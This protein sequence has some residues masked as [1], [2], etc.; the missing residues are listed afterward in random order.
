[1][2][3]QPWV[4]A[5]LHVGL[6]GMIGTGLIAVGRL[7][8]LIQADRVPG[9]ALVQ[10][11]T[12]ALGGREIAGSLSMLGLAILLLAWSR[13]REAR[14]ADHQLPV[15]VAW[16]VPLLF[17]DGFNSND[18]RVY[19]DHGW[20]LNHGF[21]PYDVGMCQQQ[22][23]VRVDTGWCGQT[24]IY[25]PLAL[26]L[27]QLVAWPEAGQPYVGLLSLRILA[28]I[29]IALLWW[30]VRRLAGTADVDPRYAVWLAVLNPIMISQGIAG[31]HIDLLM[32]GVAFA[33]LA[34][35]G[36][37]AG[38]VGGAVV[39]GIA[40]AIKQPALLVAVP[41]ALL[42]VGAARSI[43]RSGGRVVAAVG[44]AV[45]TFLGVS[46]LSGLGLGWLKATQAPFKYQNL[47]PARIVAW[48]QSAIDALFGTH[49]SGVGI[50]KLR[51]A[52]LVVGALIIVIL[53]VRYLREPFQF[54][55]AAALTWA[56]TG[57]AFREWYLI[58]WAAALPL[59]RLGRPMRVA[60]SML[61]PFAGFYLAM[62]MG[63]RLNDKL[64]FAIA[65]AAAIVANLREP[66]VGPKPL[67]AVDEP[68]AS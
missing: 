43:L 68:A 17:I 48:T 6:L 59:G 49:W 28:L 3:P 24:A 36:T 15:F 66:L 7:P 47:G 54:L 33:G 1:M 62:T 50:E 51:M 39:V 19:V 55:V 9:P 4:P 40:A 67:V 61:I 52:T 58:L 63:M 13:L 35:A 32:T 10:R 16:I 45:A 11:L 26:R 65:L 31:L 14:F 46:L 44:I 30:A 8:E 29:G 18:P 34:V 56:V 5:V 21:N 12:Q 60:A 64:A 23:P 22:S 25:P 38:L 42:P 27:F 57:G 37:R 20:L 41:V 2:K 53:A